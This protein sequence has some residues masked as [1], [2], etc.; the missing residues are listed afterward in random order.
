MI[1]EAVRL[2]MEKVQQIHEVEQSKH[3]R[4]NP[5]S[6]VRPASAEDIQRAKDAGFPNELIELYR[7]C[8]PVGY[9]E[10]K[11][12]LWSISKA[13]VENH[14]AVPGYIVFPHGFV[15]FASNLFGDAYC[16]DKNVSNPE[17][18]HPVVLFPQDVFDE[19]NPP[20]SI[21]QPFRLEVATSLED[22]LMKFTNETLIDEP[23]YG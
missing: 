2:L 11:Q 23:F 15:V 8:E 5:G 16:I 22:F 4:V 14:D 20:L 10:L 12:R 13:L 9:I 3:Q 1:S 6:R 21:V 7:E 19:E 18:N 17:G